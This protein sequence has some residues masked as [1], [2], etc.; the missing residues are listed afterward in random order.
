MK[1]DWY[2]LAT[3]MMWLALPITALNYWRVW[4]RL[5]MRMAVHFDANWQPNGY[6]SREGA[7][8]LGLGVIAFLLLLFTV[9]AYTVRTN[10][11][12]SAWPVMLMFYVA[13][14]AL[15]V[16]NNWIAQRNLNDKPQPSAS[17]R[18]EFPLGRQS[19]ILTVLQLHL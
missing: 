5:P 7:L 17:W 8:L 19:G 18:T 6:T 10:K 13:L 9:A 2:T 12:S 4:D 3:W 16:V 14:T 15:C 1:R 11:P